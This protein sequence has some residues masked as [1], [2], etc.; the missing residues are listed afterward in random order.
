MNKGAVIFLVVV[1]FTSFFSVW[2]SSMDQSVQIDVSWVAGVEDYLEQAKPYPTDMSE[3]IS[4]LQISLYDKGNLQF[5][6]PPHWLRNGDVLL[7]YLEEVLRSV[8]TLVNGS[9]PEVFIDEVLASNRVLVMR[10]KHY[11][12]VDDYALWGDFIKVLFV[13]MDN[14]DKGL[15]GHIFIK[16]YFVPEP[17]YSSFIIGK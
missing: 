3:P 12:E 14:L 17:K 13:L 1:L 2:V 6:A 8:D 11:N 4:P 9:V 5:I 16:E 7:D 15:E 10:Y